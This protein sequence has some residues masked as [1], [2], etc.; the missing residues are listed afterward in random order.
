MVIDWA[1]ITITPLVSFHTDI[2]GKGNPG[3][4]IALLS[5][6]YDPDIGF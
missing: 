6:V 2:L 1:I 4:F 3:A 5:D